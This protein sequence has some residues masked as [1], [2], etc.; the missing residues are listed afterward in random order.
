MSKD[1]LF[2]AVVDAL[3]APSNRPERDI[4]CPLWLAF[5]LGAWGLGFLITLLIGAWM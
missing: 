4:Y 5:F 1:W 3:R 2:W